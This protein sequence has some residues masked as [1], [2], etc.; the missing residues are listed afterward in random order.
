M[1]FAIAA[2]VVLALAMGVQSSIIGGIPGLGLGVHSLGLG[3]GVHGQL[4]AQGPA[5]VGLGG[6]GGLSSAVNIAGHG[7]P[8]AV[9]IAGSPLLASHGIP[10]AVNIAGGPLLAGHGISAAVAV[11]P[12]VAFAAPVHGVHGA[13]YVAQTR[14]AVHSAPLPGHIQSAASVNVAPAPGTL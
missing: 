12:H 7:I 14:G 1:K 11:A 5:V 10:A 2:V 9:N 4:L 8:A 6:L 3:H 13:S